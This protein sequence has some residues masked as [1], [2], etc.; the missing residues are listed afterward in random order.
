MPHPERVF[1]TWQWPWM[2]REWRA[3]GGLR[4]GPW[5]QLFQNAFAFCDAAREDFVMV[6]PPKK[7]S[8]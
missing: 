5:L 4:A 2:P 8:K 7:A 1:Q 6:T 3:D